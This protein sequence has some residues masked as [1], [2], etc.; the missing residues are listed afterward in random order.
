[1]EISY[2]YTLKKLELNSCAQTQIQLTQPD[3]FS[4]DG[5]WFK[6]ETS[7]IE[8]PLGVGERAG[9]MECARN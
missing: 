5:V 9:A 4:N 7:S 6:Y 1:M 8:S 3:V 2:D